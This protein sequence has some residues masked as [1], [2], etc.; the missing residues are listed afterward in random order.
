MI[1]GNMAFKISDEF[2]FE[3]TLLTFLYITCMTFLMNLQI[4]PARCLKR[5]AAT[6][7][8]YATVFHFCVLSEVIPGH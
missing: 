1:N 6:W 4:L 2:C 5:T 7:E 3:I 8:S